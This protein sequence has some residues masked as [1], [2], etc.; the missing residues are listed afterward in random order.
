MAYNLRYNP[1]HAVQGL[2]A[3]EMNIRTGQILKVS[4]KKKKKRSSGEIRSA[5]FH[6]QK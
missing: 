2:I 5:I 4:A 6:M 1:E 3:R